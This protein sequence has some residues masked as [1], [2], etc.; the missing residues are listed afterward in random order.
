MTLLEI[1]ARLQ[2]EFPGRSVNLQMGCW[3]HDN[4]KL[5]DEMTIYDHQT[6]QLLKCTSLEDGILRL[7]EALLPAKSIQ[8]DV[9]PEAQP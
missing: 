1:A 8:V 4:G 7:K 6:N 5:T 3:S 9:V 2:A